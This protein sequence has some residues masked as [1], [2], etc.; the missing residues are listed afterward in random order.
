MVPGLPGQVYLACAAVPLVMADLTRHVLQGAWVFWCSLHLA[1]LGGCM[2]IH[3]AVL[4]VTVDITRHVLQGVWLVG[5]WGH[6]GAHFWDL[7]RRAPGQDGAHALC[8]E[9]VRWC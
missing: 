9:F 5:F 2:S 1:C 7:R 8:A 6:Q 3:G 4:L